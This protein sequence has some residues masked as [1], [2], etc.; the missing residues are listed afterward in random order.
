[1]WYPY[2]FN[3]KL[4]KRRLLVTWIW[5]FMLIKAPDIA[6]AVLEMVGVIVPH[7][8]SNRSSLWHF[9]KICIIFMAHW[10]KRAGDVVLW[11][12]FS[13]WV[14]FLCMPKCKW[15]T[16]SQGSFEHKAKA[17]VM[18]HISVQIVAQ[19]SGMAVSFAHPS[20]AVG[21][22]TISS[23]TAWAITRCRD[24]QWIYDP[25]ETSGL[26]LGKRLVFMNTWF[27]LPC[28]GIQLTSTG[29]FVSESIDAVVVSGIIDGLVGGRARMLEHH[30]KQLMLSLAFL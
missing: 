4:L 6:S 26:Y 27:R 21:H 3:K 12:T 29:V 18:T 2:H 24:M 17:I 15:P 30:M 25:V 9:C 13:R 20:K 16:R 22:W 28:E 5:F 8:D 7:L 14:I 10:H 11:N 19:K 1:M 23:I